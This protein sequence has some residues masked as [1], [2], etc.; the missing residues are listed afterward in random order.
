MPNTATSSLVRGPT[1][2]PL[3]HKTIGEILKE[4][5]QRH[6]KKTALVIPWQNVRCTF[7]D[8]QA[9]SEAT[10]RALLAAGLKN[11]EMVA[12]MAGNRVEY[13]EFMLGAARVGCP[14]IVLNNTYTPS[15]LIS[16]LKRTCQYSVASSFAYVSGID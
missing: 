5:A 9:R 12:I 14:L 3:W 7:Q 1:N 16:A 11:G 4:Q 10:A 6:A 15:E 13:I 8:L 2:L